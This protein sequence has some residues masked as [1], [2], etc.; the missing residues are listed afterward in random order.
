MHS[1]FVSV[2]LA[3]LCFLSAFSGSLVE[4]RILG[5]NSSSD[6]DDSLVY[7]WPLPSKSSHGDDT[8]SV[9]PDLS[10]DVGGSGGSSSIVAEAFKRYKDII[11]KHSSRRNAVYDI[12]KIKIVVHSDNETVSLILGIYRFFFFWLW[13]VVLTEVGLCCHCLVIVLFLNSFI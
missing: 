13:V 3:V 8:I 11:F 10:L 4:G 1:N 2:F 9:D 7:L 6:L 12:S 5:F